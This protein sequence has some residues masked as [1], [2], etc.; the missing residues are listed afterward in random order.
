MTPPHD[1]QNSLKDR[2][3]IVTGATSGIGRAVALQLAQEGCNIVAVGRN[4]ERLASLEHEILQHTGVLALQ[5]DVC[6]E[7][8]MAVMAS[9]TLDRFG[10]I[11]ILVASAG[12]ARAATRKIPVPFSQLPLE[13]WNEVIDTNLHGLFLSNRAVLPAMKT[14]REGD[15]INLSSFPAGVSGQPFAASYSASK[16][17][18]IGLSESL[19]EEVRQFGIRVQTVLPGPTDTP[20][21]GQKAAARFGSLMRVQEVAEAIVHLAKLP[22]DTTMSTVIVKSVAKKERISKKSRI[23]NK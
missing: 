21:F 9:K 5:L 2:T 11:D 7:A 4:A 13:E 18:V 16:F 8:D 3:A 15:I 14:Q 10:R 22:R 23:S 20:I 6:R 19:Q 17:G 1:R 12:I